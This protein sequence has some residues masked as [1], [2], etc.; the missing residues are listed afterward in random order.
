MQYVIGCGGVGSRV[1]ELL[2]RL[3]QPIMLIDGDT[4]EEKNLDRQL[5]STEQIGQNKAQALAGQYNCSFLPEYFHSG[6]RR[7]QPQDV[8]LCCADNH[9][10]RKE[11]LSACDRDKCRSVIGGNEYT[12]AEAY[13]YEPEW[14]DTHNDPRIA[15]PEI[16]TNR[17]GDPLAPVGCVE[18]AKE[19]PQLV[20]ANAEAA[21]LM[22]HLYY[23]YTQV[24]LDLPGETMKDWPVRERISAYR[25]FVVKY[26]DL[27]H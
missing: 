19:R 6:L 4:L 11:V 2:Y 17:S 10:C 26:G 3:K 7:F 18:A 23:F 13:W 12:D 21:V 5:F 16:L 27:P 15:Y 25:P 9:A 22:M 8:L 14:K 1:A 20:L 24:C